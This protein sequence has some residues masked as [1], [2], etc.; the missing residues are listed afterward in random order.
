MAKWVNNRHSD[1]LYADAPVPDSSVKLPESFCKITEEKR[2]GEEKS[3]LDGQVFTDWK[4]RF[5]LHEV[6]E[7]GRFRLLA[8]EDE[9][10]VFVKQK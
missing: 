10:D 6:L 9:A 3:P 7:K 2:Q 1:G 4:V 8:F 5:K